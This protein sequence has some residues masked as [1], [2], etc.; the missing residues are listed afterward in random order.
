V[1]REK[2][3]MIAPQLEWKKII[4]LHDTKPF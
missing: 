4:F 3:E 1:E 2:E